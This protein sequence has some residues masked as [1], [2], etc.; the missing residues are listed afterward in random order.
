MLRSVREL[1]RPVLVYKQPMKYEC[2]NSYFDEATNKSTNTCKWTLLEATQLQQEYES[3][4]GTGLRYEYFIIGNCPVCKGFGYLTSQRK[5]WVDCK[6]TWGPSNK[7]NYTVAGSEGSIVVELK[8][9]YKYT[10]IFNNSTKVIIDD[11]KCKLSRPP[12]K[13]GLGNETLLIITLFTAEKLTKDKI[14]T[15]KY[16]AP[17]LPIDLTVLGIE[18]SDD[19]FGLSDGSLLEI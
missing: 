2:P 10:D 4:G 1:G 5:S 12:I 15:I 7:D 17:T 13:R 9:D 14:E 16:Y 18:E 8:A 19:L 11:I 3:E 6:I